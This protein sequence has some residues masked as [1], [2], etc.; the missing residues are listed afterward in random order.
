M[1]KKKAEQ[2]QDNRNTELFEALALMEK[3]RGIPV[4]FMISQIQKAIVT[5]CKSTYNGNED[6]LIIMEPDTGIF[7]V[8][9][10]KTVVEE[11]EDDCRE[12]QLDEAR[13]IS[14]AA[15]IGDKVGIRLDTKEFGRIA[16]QKAKNIIRQGIRDSEKG[17]ALAEYQSK[18]QDI[19]TVTVEHI[20][21]NEEGEAGDITVRLGKSAA[22]LPKKEQVPNEVIKENDRIKYVKKKS[23]E[24]DGEE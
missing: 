7:E 18:L 24:A 13:K 10:N 3:E 1:K 11:V 14:A 19:V 9:L 23:S 17:Q 4:E 21:R 20:D 5:A 8:Y 12:I 22:I 6:V 2:P 15:R 16:A